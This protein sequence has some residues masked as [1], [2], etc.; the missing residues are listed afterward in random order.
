[1]KNVMKTVVLTSLFALMITMAQ[2]DPFIRPPGPVWYTPFPYQRNINMD[3]G[4]TGVNPVTDSNP[5][6]IPGANYE[7]TLD[8]EL[9]GS[10][11]VTLTG[12]ATWFSAATSPTNG[13]PGI[14]INNIGGAGPLSGTAVFTINNVDDN[15]P[16]KDIWLEAIDYDNQAFPGQYLNWSV[17]DPNGNTAAGPNGPPNVQLG[18]G[19]WLSDAEFQI[20]PNPDYETIVL[21][22]NNVPAGDFILIDD[23]HIA[24]E[25]VPEPATFSLLALGGL[26]LLWRRR[27]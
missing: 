12:A 13:I 1:M 18:T 25:S 21:S 23:F 16:L 9:W 17:Y 4:V 14:G 15:Q 24:T 7:G 26:A 20:M 3:W 5:S 19:E 2:A 8:P 27:S 6:G 10:D 11:A 22:F